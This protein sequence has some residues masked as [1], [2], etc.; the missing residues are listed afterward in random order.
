VGANKSDFT[1]LAVAL[2]RRG[3]FVLL[4]DFRAHGESGGS[5]SSL[6][7]HE[8]RDIAAALDF[9]KSRPEVDP[10]RIGIY[11][12]SMG[13]STA[14]LAAARTHAFSAIVVDSAFTSRATR[15]GPS[16]ALSF[17]IFPF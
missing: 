11:G 12:F 16:R 17:A 10:K 5:R 7:H 14:I 2:S 15:L 9:L 6:G 8:Q 13:A 3:C 1:E 4:F